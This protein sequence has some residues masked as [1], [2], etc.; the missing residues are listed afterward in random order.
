VEH[1][2]E[3]E[4]AKKGKRDLSTNPAKTGR[5]Y[6]NEERR[7]EVSRKGRKG[8]KGA[9]GRRGRVLSMN[10]HSAGQQSHEMKEKRFV[11]GRT[12]KDAKTE[13]AGNVKCRR[14]YL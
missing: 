8:R 9:K 3:R 5:I 11:R 10:G 1:G 2:T 13:D 6:T 12:G 14:N 4:D 7:K